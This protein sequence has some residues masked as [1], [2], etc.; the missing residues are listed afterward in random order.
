MSSLLLAPPGKPTP[1]HIFSQTL[2]LPLTSTVTLIVDIWSAEPV[3]AVANSFSLL[4]SH[5]P[6]CSALVLSPALL[7]CHP[8]VTVPCPDMRGQRPRLIRAHLLN[9]ARE[10]EGY[11][12]HTWD[13]LGNACAGKDLLDVVTF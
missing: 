4:Q 8:P 10:K 5:S 12:S 1:I 7:V 11:G 3:A 6:Y 13:V 2:Q 9:L